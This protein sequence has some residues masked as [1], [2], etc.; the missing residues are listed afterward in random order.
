MIFNDIGQYMLLVRL[1]HDIPGNEGVA[2]QRRRP[3]IQRDM[4]MAASL[5]GLTE[6]QAKEFQDQFKVGFQ[7][8][9]AIA[10]VAH[11]LVFAWR[12]WF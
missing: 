5:S 7:T 2:W 12:P 1:S 10:V 8:W 11:V 9:L 6:E 4:K 3:P